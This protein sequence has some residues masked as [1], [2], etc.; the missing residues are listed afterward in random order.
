MKLIITIAGFIVIVSIGY[1]EIYRSVRAGAD[2]VRVFKYNEL[3]K[4]LVT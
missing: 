1:D 4:I 3:I 2:M